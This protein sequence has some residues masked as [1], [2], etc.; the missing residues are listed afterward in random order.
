MG[1]GEGEGPGGCLREIWVGGNLFW[2]SLYSEKKA[3]FR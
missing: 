3:P 2:R 1:G